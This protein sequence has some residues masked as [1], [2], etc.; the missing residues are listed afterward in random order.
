[1]VRV[2]DTGVG[3]DE[4]TIKHVFEPFFTTKARTKGTGLGLA[5]CYGIVKQAGGYIF[6]GS[7]VGQGA[8]FDVYVPRDD[9]EPV[10]P[11]RAATPATAADGAETILLVEDEQMVMAMVEKILRVQGYEVITAHTGEEALRV[12]AERG[13]DIDLLLTDVVMPRVSGG[14]LARRLTATHPEMKVLFMSGYTEDT[15]IHQGRLEDDAAF[16]QKPFS[17]RVLAERVRDVLDRV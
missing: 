3:I 10:S 9:E 7:R 5:T 4:E 11:S 17:P 13:G 8:V 15:A 14:E 2:S 16:L 1:L 12:A 6:A